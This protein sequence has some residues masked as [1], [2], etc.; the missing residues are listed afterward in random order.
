MP[1]QTKNNDVAIIG[2]GPG[3]LAAAMLL[4]ASGARVTVYERNAVVGGRSARITLPST[5]GEY[6]FDTGPTFFLMPY[7]LEEIFNA[8]GKDLHDYADLRPLDPI[9][10][11]LIGRQDS[12]GTGAPPWTIDA[13][14]DTKR[15]AE[16]LSAIHPADGRAFARFIR[17]NRAKLAAAEPIL[18]KPITSLLD[19]MNPSS[20]RAGLHIKPHLTVASLLAKYFEHPASR[21][22]VSFQSKYLGMSPYDCP[23][24]FTILPFIEYEYGIWHPIGGCNALMTAMADA[25]QELGVTI[26]TD[27]E[28][29][30]L[31]FDASGPVPRITGLT[32]NGQHQRYDKVVINADA[33][34][35]MKHLIPESLR[36][37][38]SGWTDR[39]IDSKK[40]SCSTYMLY[41]G[42]DGEV[43][44][45][46]HHTIFV[47]ELYKENLNDIS[48]TGS[49]SED[50]SVYVC[51]PSQ[52]DPS[53]SPEGKSALYVL[54][55]TPNTREGKQLDWSVSAREDARARVMHQL[56]HRFGIQD[57]ESRIE[58]EHEITPSGWQAQQIN[59]GATFNLAHNLN[60][61][62]HKRP[63]HKLQGFEG[64]YLV[65][66][67][68]HPGSGLP[69]IFLSSQITSKILCDKLGLS[70]AGAS[71]TMNTTIGAE[72]SRELT[73]SKLA[74]PSP[75]SEHPVTI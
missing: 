74:A 16:Q 10:R 73:E 7:V 3:G 21:L 37:K 28:V 58:A 18:R 24:L 43:D 56:E 47:S 63:Q 4:A 50:P 38:R 52:L 42:I 44:H 49:L 15:M 2:A 39:T 46:P 12:P 1:A 6:H 26:H 59:F 20:A 65:G 29:T 48:S 66:G 25:A 54:M 35:A 57:I 14:T 40:Y 68:T 34:H 31:A 17:D 67:G 71:H 13:T 27:A 23:S 33:T 70:Y 75:Q 11:L 19:L 9:Y 61:M 53:M 32:V 30:N 60:Q 41:L 45:L 72:R 8:A 22:A 36:S 62:L 5:T 51:N 69:V 64:V 55:P